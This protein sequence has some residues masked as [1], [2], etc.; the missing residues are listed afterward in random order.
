MLPAFLAGVGG[1]VGTGQQG[2][3]WIAMDDL[4][5]LYELA[6]RNPAIEGPLNAVHPKP[7]SQK[8]FSKVLGSVLH[9]PSV[10]PLPASV[11]KFLF[12]Q[13]GE[14][15]LLADLTV[16]PAKA[17]ELGHPFRFSDLEDALSF[18]LGKASR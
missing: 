9:R 12:G 3:S 1:P 10:L 15:T 17:N 5:D 6:V 18:M 16:S 13:M 4:L 7:V 14:E 2:F 11:V 8:Q